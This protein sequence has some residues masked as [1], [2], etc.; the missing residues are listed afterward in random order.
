MWLF[1]IENNK[2]KCWIRPLVK[3]FAES[4]TG[5]DEKDTLSC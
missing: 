5:G 3:G 4:G 2:G 1:E